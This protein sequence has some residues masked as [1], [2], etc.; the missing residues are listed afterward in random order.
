MEMVVISDMK[1]LNIE[2]IFVLYQQRVIVL[3]FV[4]T[5]EL[6]E[7]IKNNI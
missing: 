1:I 7:N 3:L 5:N 4:I 2:E 6:V